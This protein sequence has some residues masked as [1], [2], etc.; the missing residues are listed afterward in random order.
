MDIPQQLTA[1]VVSRLRLLRRGP[2]P[3]PIPEPPPEPTP[4][5]VR[6]RFGCRE[7]VPLYSAASCSEEAAFVIKSIQ[8]LMRSG[9]KPSE[10]AVLYRQHDIASAT[11]MALQARPTAQSLAA[12][13]QTRAES[14][15]PSQAVGLRRGLCEPQWGPP[16]VCWGACS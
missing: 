10:I 1:A 4:Q 13:F 7:Q 6:V 16:G 8:Q 9:L 14:A 3:E 15:T 12:A 5:R 2:A 11:V